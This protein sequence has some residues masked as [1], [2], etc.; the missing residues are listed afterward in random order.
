MP[1][2]SN[3]RREDTGLVSVAPTTPDRYA[4]GTDETPTN[5]R[6]DD[7]GGSK[8]RSFINTNKETPTST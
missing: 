8:P 1:S 2:G 6:R 3:S 5:I 7:R 4:M